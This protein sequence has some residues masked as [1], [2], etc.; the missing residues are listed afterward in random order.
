M[1]TSS[2]RTAI[3]VALGL[4]AA[5]FALP[6]AAQ[7]DYGLGRSATDA[8]VNAW[9]IDVRPDFKGLPKGSG[10]VDDG[11]ELWETTCASCH[12][13]FAESNLVFT[14]LIGGTTE[15]DIE[16]GR[17]ASLTD[18]AQTTRTAIMTVPTVSTLWDYIYR[19]MP[20]DNPRSLTPDEVY[21]SLA[22]LL[23]LAE[24]VDYDFT[25]S[26]ENIQE[27]QDRM[28]NRNGVMF[29]E[30]LWKADGKPDTNNKACMKDCVDKVDVSSEL[31]DYAR[32]ANGDW[33]AQMRIVGPVRGVNAFEPALT[34]TVD[35]NADKVREYARSTMADPAEKASQSEDGEVTEDGARLLEL[36]QEHGCMAC[37]ARDTKVLGPSF[38]DISD[39]YKDDDAHDKLVNKVLKG[40]SGVW[41]PVPMP[42][43]PDL[44]DD[45]ASAL[46]D[47]ILSGAPN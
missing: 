22:Y 16:T 4:A 40:G 33:A 27:V 35:D 12:G 21:A 31:P 46:V 28:P 30:G 5:V 18:P 34:G 19:A 43:N 1:F 25:L 41:G 8:E 14:P 38:L 24:I 2:K 11:E 10:T 6:A 26:D 23:S 15:D 9:D 42:A 13:S 36:A 3:S 29:W 39:K 32:D 44:S 47:W 17:V 20:W 7:A 37:H 45:E